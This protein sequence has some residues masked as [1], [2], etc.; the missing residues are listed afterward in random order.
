MAKPDRPRGPAARPRRARDATPARPPHRP[1]RPRH[2]PHRLSARCQHRSQSAATAQH[3]ITRCL[4]AD[5]PQ[6]HSLEGGIADP[7]ER[8]VR[9]RTLSCVLL[10]WVCA[11]LTPPPIDSGVRTA[12]GCGELAK[13]I[14]ASRGA[15]L[16]V[17]P[18]SHIGSCMAREISRMRGK[19]PAKRMPL[20]PEPAA[21]RSGPPIVGGKRTFSTPPGVVRDA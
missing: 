4:I 20:P 18:P 1:S 2:R 19:T 5:A 7:R 12:G 6:R 15:R 14:T 11:F 21:G 9:T 10:L 17:S 16:S 8:T 3:E 13:P